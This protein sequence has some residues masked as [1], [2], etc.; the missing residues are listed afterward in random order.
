MKHLTEDVK[1]IEK[2]IKDIHIQM[3]KHAKKSEGIGVRMKKGDITSVRVDGSVGRSKI[4]TILG[5][6][7]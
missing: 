3:N 7:V 2:D 6:R 4:D 5:Q 1:E